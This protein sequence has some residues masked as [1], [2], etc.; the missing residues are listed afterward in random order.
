MKVKAKTSF[1]G[2]ITLAIGEVGDIED[3]FI[4]N[5]LLKAGYIEPVETDGDKNQR[6]NADLEGEKKPMTGTMDKEQ[7]E[8]MTVPQLK[9]LAKEMGLDDSGRKAELIERISAAEVHVDVENEA[10]GSDSE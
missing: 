2:M 6:T 1:S 7:L 8:K 3:D 9:A 4:L 10:E 5:D